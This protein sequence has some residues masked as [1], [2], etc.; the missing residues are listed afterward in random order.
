MFA[1]FVLAALLGVFGSG[2]LS[3]AE[4]SAGSAAVEIQGKM[5]GDRIR[6]A[7]TDEDEILTGRELH[8]LGRL[9][10][11]KH[12][13]MERAGHITVAPRDSEK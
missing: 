13:V 6:S 8:G 12:A 11:I 3:R 10:R 2:P 7:G 1:L 9:D 4:S 5:H